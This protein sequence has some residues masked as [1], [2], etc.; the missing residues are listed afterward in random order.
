MPV[1]TGKL[2]RKT[3]CEPSWTYRAEMAFPTS[4][5]SFFS[6]GKVQS[7]LVPYGECSM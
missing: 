2:R 4:I 3:L 7:S 5:P 1:V 6:L